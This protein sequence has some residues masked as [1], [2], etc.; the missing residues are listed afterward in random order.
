MEFKERARDSFDVQTMIRS[1]VFGMNSKT[2][3]TRNIA[4]I[5]IMGALGNVLSWISISLAP[6]LP[7]IPLGP[8]SVGIALDLSHLT[9]FITALYGGPTIGGL[10]GL[11]G[12]LIAA[13]EFGFSKGNLVNGFLLPVGKMLTGITSGLIMRSLG[14]QNRNR[15]RILIIVSTLLAYIPEAIFTALIFLS[16]LPM[17]YGTPVF[18][19]Y[20]ILVG[21]LIK[22]FIEMFAIGVVLVALSM[23]RGFTDFVGSYFTAS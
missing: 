17:V 14:I 10:T 16:I 4:F 7:E 19:L 13:N 21:I 5:G 1:K 11:I 15:Y 18:I 2:M 9:T 6:L 23:N 3:S 12:G 20:P 8:F 22:A